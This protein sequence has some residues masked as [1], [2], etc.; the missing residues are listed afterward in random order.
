MSTHCRIG[1]IYDDNNIVSV[2]CHS[3]GYPEDV[4]QK[5]LQHYTT[6]DQVEKLIA[7]GDLSFLGEEPFDDPSLWKYAGAMSKGCRTYKGRGE[8]TP[9]VESNSYKDFYELVNG[10][11]LYSYLFDK[12]SGRWIIL[13]SYGKD[14]DSR[15]QYLDEFE[16]R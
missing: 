16:F 9:A 12:A 2:Y 11:Y 14:S 7:L 8:D 3:D 5:L 4:G 13:N 6:L 15:I 10:N 1:I